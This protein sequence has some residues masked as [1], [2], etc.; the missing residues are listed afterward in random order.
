MKKLALSL[1]LGAS[2]AIAPSVFALTSMTDANMKSAT[3]Q[4]GVS[5]A[6]DGVKIESFTGSTAYIDED[7]TGVGIG[8]AIIISDR[9]TLKNYDALG[10]GDGYKAQFSRKVNALMGTAVLTD[11]DVKGSITM[12]SGLTIDV[13][14]CTLLSIS[15]ALNAAGNTDPGLI[16]ADGVM[17][18]VAAS[19]AITTAT[20]T[21]ALAVYGVVIGLPTL[22]IS[23][24]SDSYTVS[25]AR[26]NATDGSF[27][28]EKDYIKIQKGA[29]VMAI[30]GGS[31]EIA[32]H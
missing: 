9:H 18:Y 17:D 7:G 23:T 19:G 27:E 14:A 4:A 24:S 20:T 13:G 6:V 3:G 22:M 8:G 26:V 11:A 1:V 2:L 32:A 16:T 31:V 29:S 30:L 25:A 12:T 5:I 15:N 21:D 28:L 10:N